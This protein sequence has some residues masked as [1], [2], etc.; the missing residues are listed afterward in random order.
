MVHFSLLDGSPTTCLK[1]ALH[2]LTST[3]ATVVA[4]TLPCFIHKHGVL[5]FETYNGQCKASH[6]CLQSTDHHVPCFQLDMIG[7]L[8]TRL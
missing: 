2:R 6:C 7:T 3:A 5:A 1:Q 8:V 4:G